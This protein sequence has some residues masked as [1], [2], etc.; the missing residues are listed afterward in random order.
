MT[1]VPTRQDR[2]VLTGV[3]AKPCGWPA[4]S[5]DPGSGRH[6][7]APVGTRARVDDQDQIPLRGVSTVSGDCQVASGC[8]GGAEQAFR[9]GAARLRGRDGRFCFF[10]TGPPFLQADRSSR[11]EGTTSSTAPATVAAATRVRIGAEFGNSHPAVTSP[12]RA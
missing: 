12:T 1:R 8:P 7:A 6:K 4:A 11:P 5:L 3:K 10:Q 2:A 9:N